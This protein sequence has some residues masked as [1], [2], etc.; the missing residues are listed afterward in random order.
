LKKLRVAEVKDD[1]EPFEE[2]K[3]HRKS[4]SK[5]ILRNVRAE[6]EPQEPQAVLNMALSPRGLRIPGKICRNVDRSMM[7]PSRWGE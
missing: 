4:L 6:K 7:A 2:I 1:R 3:P 5:L